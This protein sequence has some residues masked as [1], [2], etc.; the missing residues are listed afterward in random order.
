MW[1]LFEPDNEKLC[2]TDSGISKLSA[3]HSTN[4]IMY[5][6]NGQ[7]PNIIKRWDHLWS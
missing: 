2:F 3:Y 4:E 6:I 1:S 7:V 5:N